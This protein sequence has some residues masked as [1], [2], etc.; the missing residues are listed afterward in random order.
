M[1]QKSE[2]DRLEQYVSKLLSQYDQLRDENA[3]LQERLN[4]REEEI[5]GLKSQVSTADSER[6]DISVRIKGLIDK[7]E[8]WET[9]F[10][11][12]ESMPQTESTSSATADTSEL[13]EKVNE[14]AE[15][16]DAAGEKEKNQQ[17]NLFNVQPR[18]DSFGN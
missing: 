12:E 6:G 10:A 1:D 2:F 9:A 4:Q 5:R 17:Q 15:S 7:I 11:G 16:V 14:D 13:A 3:R 18:K 8:E